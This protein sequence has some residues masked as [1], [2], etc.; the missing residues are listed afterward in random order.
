MHAIFDGIHPVQVSISTIQVKILN[1]W[2]V[3]QQSTTNNSKPAGKTS[4]RAFI[5]INIQPNS[6]I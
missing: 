1:Y 6:T 5:H 3:S 2:V 4:L